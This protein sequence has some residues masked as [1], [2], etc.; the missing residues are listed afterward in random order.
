MSQK[1]LSDKEYIEICKRVSEQTLKWYWPRNWCF[2]S[3]REHKKE[4]NM[5]FQ[6]EWKLYIANKPNKEE[7][8]NH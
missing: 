3:D 8:K 1:P 2:K 7:V 4:K 5:T 6:Q